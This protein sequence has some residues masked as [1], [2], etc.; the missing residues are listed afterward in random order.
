VIVSAEPGAGETL[1]NDAESARRHVEMAGLEPD[2][3]G[4]RHPATFVRY[5]DIGNEVLAA[6][7]TRIEAISKAVESSNRHGLPLY[8]LTIDASVSARNHGQHYK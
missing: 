1:Q 7:A 4:I 6:S 8:E 3:I 5:V 2:T